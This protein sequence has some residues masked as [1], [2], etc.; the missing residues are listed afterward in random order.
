VFSQV[1]EWVAIVKSV[2]GSDG[3][4][5]QVNRN[6]KILFIFFNVLLSN[7]ESNCVGS[8][9]GSFKYFQFSY[10]LFFQIYN[11]R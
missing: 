11:F 10:I 3:F 9:C 7:I 5:S 8:T 6:K 4:F 1:G 2:S